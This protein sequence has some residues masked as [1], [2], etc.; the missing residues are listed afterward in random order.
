MLLYFFFGGGSSFAAGMG[1]A[2]YC[3]HGDGGP[4]PRHESLWTWYVWGTWFEILIEHPLGTRAPKYHQIGH[5]ARKSDDLS[6]G[7]T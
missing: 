2:Y 6:F 7:V 5:E 3:P 1:S 4:F